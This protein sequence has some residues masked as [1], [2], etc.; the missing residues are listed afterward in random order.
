MTLYELV[1]FALGVGMFPIPLNGYPGN[2]KTPSRT[3][4]NS[5]LSDAGSA[6]A[7]DHLLKHLKMQS[8]HGR[9]GVSD[10]TTLKAL[11]KGYREQAKGNLQAML[12]T[13]FTGEGEGDEW[14]AVADLV[15][16]FVNDLD[17]LTDY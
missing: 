13:Y 10:N 5:L 7:T 14:E 15:N 4:L 6:V 12:Y 3:T 17:R 11:R 9:N 8:M 16:Q 2:R 1:W